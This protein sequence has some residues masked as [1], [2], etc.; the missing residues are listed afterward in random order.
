MVNGNRILFNREESVSLRFNSF[1]RSEGQTHLVWRDAIFEPS[2]PQKLYFSPQF[3][4]NVLE[5]DLP[6]DL[7]LHHSQCYHQHHLSSVFL[8]LIIDSDHRSE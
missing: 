1:I 3:I 8:V 7:E 4:E 2:F 5:R 6:V